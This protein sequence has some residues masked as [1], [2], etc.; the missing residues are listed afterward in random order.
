MNW[1]TFL[2]ILAYMIALPFLCGWFLYRSVRHLFRLSVSMKTEVSCPNCGLAVSLVGI[3]QCTCGFT[4]AGN[5]IMECP[6]CATVPRFVRCPRCQV[7]RK[8]L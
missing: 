4:Y 7:T 2:R 6:V 3:W 1:F 8:L 5:L